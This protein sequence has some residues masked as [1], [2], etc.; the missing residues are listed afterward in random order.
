MTAVDP[1][2]AL[3]A[4][5]AASALLGA[6]VAGIAYRGAVRNDS[7]TMRYLAVG[8]AAVTVL[9]FFVDYGL[10][11]VAGLSDAGTLLGVLVVFNA[12][13]VTFLYSLEGA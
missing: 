6:I 13:L 12:G 11:P 7:D 10:A 2:T 1:A 9:P 3:F 5:A 4:T 8:V